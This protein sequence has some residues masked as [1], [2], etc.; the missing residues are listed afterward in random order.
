LGGIACVDLLVTEYLPCV[1]GLITVGSQAPLLYEI[2]ALSSLER[3]EALPEHFPEWLN[4]WDR[5]DFLSY[6]ASPVFH[7]PKVRDHQVDSGQPF[8]HPHSAYWGNPDTWQ[9]IKQFLH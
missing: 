3:S 9:A 2:G 4:V 8:P 7:S 1:K 5:C 6:L